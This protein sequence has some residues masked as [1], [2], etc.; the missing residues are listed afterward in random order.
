MDKKAIML[1]KQNQNNP[2]SS[3]LMSIFNQAT[4]FMGSVLGPLGPREAA[5]NIFIY[6]EHLTHHNYLVIPCPHP[7]L[8]WGLT[9]K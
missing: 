4:I 1:N 9:D 2:L 6:I 5:W 3:S 7:Q 8:Y